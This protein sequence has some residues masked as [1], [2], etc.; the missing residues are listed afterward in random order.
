MDER[1]ATRRSRPVQGWGVR[2]SLR[3][4]F[5]DVT[6]PRHEERGRDQESADEERAAD[7]D[8]PEHRYLS[9]QAGSL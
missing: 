1:E 5:G 8:P 4:L 3:N 2:R 9:S 6:R 7:P